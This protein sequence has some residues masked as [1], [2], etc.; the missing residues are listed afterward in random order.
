MRSCSRA[1]SMRSITASFYRAENIGKFMVPAFRGLSR[2]LILIGDR[3]QHETRKTEL[4]QM[5]NWRAQQRLFFVCYWQSEPCS[6]NYLEDVLNQR[7]RNFSYAHKLPWTRNAALSLESLE[8]ISISGPKTSLS[9]S[10]ANWRSFSV[11][12]KACP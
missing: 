5:N 10:L 3:G 6:S 1:E 9:V 8:A 7:I 11:K 2:S 4:K 12:P